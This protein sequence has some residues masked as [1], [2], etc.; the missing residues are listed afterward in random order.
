MKR[1]KVLLFQKYVRSFV[2]S[3]SKY[4]NNF[5]F[6]LEHREESN[7][8]LYKRLNNFDNE[9][10]RTKTS[11]LF[12]L[13]RLVGIPN[14]R[15]KVSNKGDMFFTY[16]CLVLGN[17]PYCIYS[18]TG[19]SI[20]NYDRIIANNPIAR[21]I[22]SFAIKRKNLKKI[23]FLSQAAQKSFLTSAKYSK[24]VNKIAQEKSTYC[25]PL[26]EAQNYSIKK[27]EGDLKILFIG[28]FYIKG[29]Q[30]L[31]NA[32]L[33]LR[34]KYKNINLTIITSLGVMRKDDIDRIKN[35]DGIDLYDAK[36]SKEELDEFYRTHHVFVM[37]TFRDG[38]GLVWI[39]ALSHAMPI[40]GTEQYATG[41]FC[42]NN[43]NGFMYPNHPLQDYNPETFEIYGKYYNPKDFY[44]TLFKYQ[45]EGKLKPVEDFLYKSVE[46]LILN[47]ELIEKFSKNSIDIF[48]KK[49]H[50]KVISQ[51]IESIFL[52]AVKK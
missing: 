2:T 13:R 10:R 41:E 43:Y 30:E 27:K 1:Y 44:S 46:K 50:P 7:K 23:I 36:F 31:V 19:L 28:T 38:F 39:E 33:D 47:P 29:G 22:A 40:I 24:R 6:V 49:F 18:E 8:Q 16:G 11:T 5:E 4:L 25:Y 15:I 3:F 20:Y 34:K 26:M 21:L 42:T 52:D 9:V 45:K 17:K 32:F 51:R 35:I 14:I 37:P 12:K 48:N